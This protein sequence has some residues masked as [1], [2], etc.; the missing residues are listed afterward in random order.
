MKLG[1]K[2]KSLWDWADLLVV[3][4]VLLIGGAWLT[5]SQA[6]RQNVIEQER[7]LQ[8]NIVEDTRNNINI[9]NNYRRSITGLIL[10]GLDEKEDEQKVKLAAQALT[11]STLPQL[12]GK[13][14]GQLIIFLYSSKLIIGNEPDISLSLADLSGAELEGTFLQGANFRF[15]NLQDVD[16]RNASL[17][18][19]QFIDSDIDRADFRGATFESKFISILLTGIPASVG[20]FRQSRGWKDALF[21]NEVKK[22]IE[23]EDK[24]YKTKQK[25]RLNSK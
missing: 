21:D 11:K 19:A 22:I 18:D 25:E 23:K 8:Q 10:N 12:D 7:V 20:N 13:R 2:D 9:L 4:L 5:Q 16:F 24:I 17:K 1:V 15:S 3:P 14:K 6:E